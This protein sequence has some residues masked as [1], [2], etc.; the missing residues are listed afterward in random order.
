MI[1][2]E[3]ALNGKKIFLAGAACEYGV[4]SAILTWVRRDMRRHPEKK[5]HEASEEE[6]RLDVS[7]AINHAPDD[8][9]NLKGFGGQ[10]SLGDEISI[11][12]IETDQT[13]EPSTR[14][15]RDP[16][17]VRKAK[18]SYYLSLKREFEGDV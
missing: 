13:D 9:E 1:G 5:N 6:L 2:F 14:S 17:L 15:R 3:I 7:G 16:E 11:K 12:I 10:L 8:D 18:R 4:L